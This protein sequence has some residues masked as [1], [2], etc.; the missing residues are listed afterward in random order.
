MRAAECVVRHLAAAERVAG[1]AVHVVDILLK[2]VTAP[3]QSAHLAVTG[4]D[5]ISIAERSGRSDD[6]SLFSKRAD[7]KRDAALS[8]NLLEA[9]VDDAGSD[10]RFVEG[11]NL[12]DRQARVELWIEA[13]IVAND[14]H[15]PPQ[16]RT[17]SF[18]FLP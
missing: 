6:G 10:H 18:F 17:A 4:N 16:V 3:K 1:V 14:V 9:I 7:V 5:P 8:L 15:V 11:D 2:R 13:S 12:V